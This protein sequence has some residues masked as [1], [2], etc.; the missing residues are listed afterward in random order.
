M[1]TSTALKTHVI[2]M[3]REGI[4][5][6]FV[7]TLSHDGS[8]L[9]TWEIES[10]RRFTRALAEQKAAELNQATRHAVFETR[11]LMEVPAT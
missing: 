11:E 5:L 6:C 3:Q 9:T 2:A 4:G 1:A 8:W 7:R 10:A